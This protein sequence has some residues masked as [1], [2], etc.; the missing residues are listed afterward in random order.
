MADR[1]DIVIFGATGFTGMHCIPYIHQLAKS[2]KYNI[3]WGVSGRSEE[4]LKHVLNTMGK[5]VDADLSTVPLI[6]SNVED[7]DSLF[8]MAQKAKVVINCVGPYV[9]YGE[10]VVDAC[11]K[12][13]THYVDVSGEPQFMENIQLLKNEIAKE[14]GVY[15]ISACGLDSIPSDLGVVYLQQ[16]F[17][18]VLNSVVTYLEF[19]TEKDNLGSIINYG[20]WQSAVQNVSTVNKLKEIRKELFPTRLPQ[21]RPKLKPKLWP[22][23]AHLVNGWAVPFLGADRSVIKRTQRYFYEVENRRPVQVDTLFALKSVFHV[24]MLSIMAIIFA[25]FSKFSFGRKLLLN[26]PELFSFGIF[27]K[28]QPSEEDIDNS[29][30]QITL[31]GEGWKEKL[32]DKNDQYTEPCNK[33]IIGRVK[34]RN[35]GYGTTCICLVAAAVIVLQEKHKLAGNGQGGVYTPGVAFANTSLIKILND[36]E[37][38]FD[39]I[40]DINPTK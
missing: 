20:T 39:I 31:Y 22:H 14:K 28:K 16:N 6:V 10:S 38:T 18:G 5:K 29:M 33:K 30:F 7:D 4:K 32:T 1:L 35:P 13:G 19:W 26:Y 27:S 21:F 11:L 17:D 3:S 8:K 37:V 34:G 25:V 9:L 24:I 23:Q 40:S 15:V 36:N 2:E 12:A